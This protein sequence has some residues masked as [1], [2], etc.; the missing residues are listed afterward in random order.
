MRKGEKKTFQT[1]VLKWYACNGRFFPWRKTNNP[2]KVLTAELLLQKTDATK[3]LPVFKKFSSHWP[4]PQTLS[5]ARISSISKVIKPLG[6]RYKAGRLKA[7]ASV[8]AADGGR[9]PG[10][11]EV[12]LKLSGVGRYIASSVLCFAFN[13]PRAVVDTNVIRILSRFFGLHSVKARPREDRFLWEFAQSLVPVRKSKEYN[14]G[15]LDFGALVC[16]SRDPH[17]SE[18]MLKN[19]CHYFKANKTI[20]KMDKRK[21][22]LTAV[23]LFAGA[24]GLSL[25]FEKAGFRVVFAVE[26]DNYSA[27]TYKSN[28]EGNNT[29]VIV[30]DIS[31]VNFGGVLKD[32][33]VRKGEIDILLAGPPCQ[34][35]SSSNMKTRNSS[36]PQN[37]LFI[38]FLRAVVQIY[39]SWILIENVSGFKN[40]EKGKVIKL[41]CYRLQKLG[42]SC[43][44]DI[45]NAADYGIPQIRRRFILVANRCGVDFNFP[46]PSFGFDGKPYL[47]VRDAISDLPI[48]KNGNAVDSLPYIKNGSS[49]SDYQNEMR[50]KWKKDY[51]LNNLTTKNSE[52]IL[53]RYR[54]IPQGGNWQVIPAHLM[55]DYKDKN[56]CHSGLYK[57]LRWNEPAIVINNFRKNMLIHPKENRNLTIREA[58]RLQSFP[59]D[60]IFWGPLNSQQQ[61]IANAVPPWL[62]SVF[63]VSIAQ[64]RNEHTS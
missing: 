31:K 1:T 15:L 51:C 7:L 45:V 44:W 59:D 52:I 56:N 54:A 63:S 50:K 47:N 28:R 20:W 4:S 32:N 39:P 18:C 60:Y 24:G 10:K 25:G 11:E 58:A 64:K 61:Q 38:D 46:K 26:N 22:Q 40:F 37:Y 3:V 36:N 2:Y 62:A 35:F 33:K 9:V 16:R 57:R 30:S 21:K 43:K 23:D 27:E 41:M 5:K 13:E 49:L 19:N 17:C 55:S 29:K 53:L 48:V 12:L 8:L 34:G 14:W 6:L 42:Y